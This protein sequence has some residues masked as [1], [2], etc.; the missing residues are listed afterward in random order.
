LVSALQPLKI[1]GLLLGGLIALLACLLLAVKLFVNPN[2]YKARIT[3]AVKHASGRELTLAGDIKLA[4]FPWVALDLG[5]V[6]L[7]NPPGFEQVPFAAV[8]HAS[9]RVKLLPLLRK[10]LQVGR[11][12][13][14]GLDLRLVKN[15]A[16]HG[17]WEGFGG[18]DQAAPSSATS[19]PQTLPDLAGLI[20]KD[21]RVSFQDMVADHINL[22]VGHLASGVTVPVDLKVDLTT[23]PGAQPITVAGKLELTPDAATRQ[24]RIANL[25]LE[26]TLVPAAGSA[27]V[28]WKF[29][30][31]DLSADLAAQTLTAGA[32]A[33]DFAGAHLTGSLDGSHIVDAAT[34]AG[35]FKLDPLS[36]RE[37][38]SRLGMTAPVTRDPKVLARIGAS[39]EFSYG[40]NALSA[41][42]LNVR[43]DDSTLQGE[44]AITN[45]DTKALSFDLAVDRIDVDRYL[46][47]APPK[48]Q[49]Q[50]QPPG[51]PAEKAAEV[52]TSGLKA[53]LLHGTLS[54]GSATVAGINLRQV[55]FNLDAKDGV[56]HLA[57]AKAQLYGGDYAGDITLDSR[58]ATPALQLDQRM[59]GI[60]VGQLLSDLAK[61]RRLS[62]RGNVTSSLTA[63][64]ADADSI[65]KSLNGHVDAN[66]ANGAVEGIDLWFEINRAVSLIQKQ[67]L[68]SGASSGRTR[69]DTFKASADLNN[70]VATTKD[71]N[72]ASQNLH[73]SG[74]GT[75]N[76]V[77]EALDYQLRA[78]LYKGAAGAK[79][80]TLAEVPVTITGTMSSPKVSPDL[81][82]MARAR[83]QQELDKHKEQLMQQAQDKLQNLFK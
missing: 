64:G 50:P 31:P 59:T 45:L 81:G 67:A 41:D 75:S 48:T 53:L 82:G 69:F 66:L 10:E 17:N 29:A 11:V 36:P 60:D 25:D 30:V 65:L 2:A 56:A 23:G 35:S 40:G 68:P 43:F 61:S 24:Y 27:A 62:G 78:T 80:G 47:P 77:T 49:A 26:G 51:K 12:E 38:M 18:K 63:R 37:L 6:S 71:L 54:I 32:F 58:G 42:K 21:S 76:L 13:I 20:V 15:A 19:G 14:D 83:V 16:G 39:G 79:S 72:I 22:N 1:L 74:Q 33:A 46:S 8:K 7:G 34:L 44:A 5:A 73:V 52:P 55:L 70:G 57:P 3:Q 9:V 28:P 4:V